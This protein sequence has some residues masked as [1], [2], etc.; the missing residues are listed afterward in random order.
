M[1]HRPMR[2]A[3]ILLALPLLAT[4]LFASDAQSAASDPAAR[5][6]DVFVHVPAEAA[7]GGVVP[8]QIE[9]FGFPTAVTLAVI[10]VPRGSRTTCTSEASIVPEASHPQIALNAR[11]GSVPVVEHWV[12]SVA[13]LHNKYR[14]DFVSQLSQ[15]RT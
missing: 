4:P 14:Y 11:P 7:P 13:C 15:N 8:V 9:A 12:M 6:L 5:G 1:S 3:S 2:A 10:R